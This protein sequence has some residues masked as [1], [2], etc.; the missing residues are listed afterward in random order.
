MTTTSQAVSSFDAILTYWARLMRDEAKALVER[1][2]GP[3][4]LR[5]PQLL[6][7]GQVNSLE[8]HD[9]CSIS[10]N[11]LT[12]ELRA[13]F[14]PIDNCSANFAQLH[15]LITQ[16]HDH[17]FDQALRFGKREFLGRTYSYPRCKATFA[18]SGFNDFCC[19]SDHASVHL[20]V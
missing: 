7:E 4:N 13:Y 12:I 18:N 9:C 11:A 3:F 19:S 20:T 2:F 5:R 16:M 15:I 17:C 10:R 8:V 1:F 14:A 6:L